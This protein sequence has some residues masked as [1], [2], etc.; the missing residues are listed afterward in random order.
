MFTSC[1]LNLTTLAMANDDVYNICSFCNASTLDKGASMQCSSC[2]HYVHY[3]CTGLP[4]YMI[5]L[6][7][8]SNRKYQCE[9]CLKEKRGSWMKD[10]EKIDCEIANQQQDK[11]IAEYKKSSPP[12]QT[13]NVDR[14]TED[15]EEEESD[16][17][18]EDDSPYVNAVDPDVT[19][20]KI[21]SKPQDT[22]NPKTPICRFYK[23]GNCKFGKKGKNC[24]FEH[25]IIC[26]HSKTKKGCKN[27]NCNYWHPPSC[28]YK[29]KCK[30]E[31]CQL[32]HPE[33]K[34]KPSGSKR[35]KL[36]TRPQHKQF[37]NKDDL[38]SK[39]LEN[40]QKKIFGDVMNMV[41][42]LS[43]SIPR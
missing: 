17:D 23:S 30:Y 25:P 37:F 27:K 31:G 10:Y 7:E 41:L 18:D 9:K 35:N 16:L 19:M 24:K 26:W 32:L 3:L 15:T 20:K 6:L 42:S 1:Q 14:E 40:F 5:L 36:A 39:S 8:T 29:N 21:Q 4:T 33:T 28:Q 11:D 2:S 38:I 13:K 43:R 34:N 12:K 22:F